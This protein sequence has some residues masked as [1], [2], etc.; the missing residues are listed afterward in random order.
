MVD[1]GVDQAG[2]LK[3]GN[4]VRD[5]MMAAACSAQSTDADPDAAIAEVL[6]GWFSHE[7]G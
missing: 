4:L 1:F 3:L 7:Q 5:K 2:S 6:D